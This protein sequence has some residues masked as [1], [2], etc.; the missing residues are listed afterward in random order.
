VLPSLISS[1]LGTDM[2]ALK[3]GFNVT[4]NQKENFYEKYGEI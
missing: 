2:V 4:E 3:L 1:N